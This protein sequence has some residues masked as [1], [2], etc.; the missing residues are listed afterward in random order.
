ME[1]QINGGYQMVSSRLR[2]TIV[3]FALCGLVAGSAFAGVLT[4]APTN[5][6]H[7]IATATTD[8]QTAPQI[9]TIGIAR[10]AGQ[11]FIL[12]FTLSNA[13]F[14]TGPFTLVYGGAALGVANVQRSGGTGATTVEFDVNLTGGGTAIG[15]T[16]TL[17]SVAPN[18]ANIRFAA[19]SAVGTTTTV[20][21]DARD[22]ISALDTVPGPYT[23]TLATLVG[24]ASIFTT[25]GTNPPPNAIID[26]TATVPLTT[27]VVQTS[28][29]ASADDD[30]ALIAKAFFSTSPTTAG[31][32]NATNT[33]DYT[34]LAGD[35]VTISIGGDFSGL[36]Q[37][38][39]NPTNHAAPFTS[40]PANT[41]TNEVFTIAAD[42]RSASI[43][44]DGNRLTTGG[45]I[46]FT[47]TASSAL[48]PRVFS[49]TEA[50]TPVAPSQARTIGTA[51]TWY[52]WVQ[53]G[54]TIV[55]P[56]VSFTPGNGVKFRFTN[57]SGTAIN[58]L[59]AV[60]LDQPTATFT[61]NPS[62]L[63][64]SGQF[65]FPVPAG[66]SQQITFSDLPTANT[67]EIGPI[68]T[69]LLTGVAPV[70]GKVTFTALTASPNVA[71]LELIYSPV[72]VVSLINLPQNPSW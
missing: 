47:K 65:I 57:S 2:T 36:V 51:A 40:A 54:T 6:A 32:R 61:Y 28:V 30:T 4:N 44:V 21:A 27:F 56:Y 37:V 19:A 71:G 10:N 38:V 26:A 53:N 23:R 25:A 1:K 18:G 45:T 49:I 11:N 7:E 63:N 69:A 60:V 33:A 29:P 41:T 8:L 50:I 31:V 46:W 9:Y 52:T 55:A 66:S 42:L 22:V 13:V 12:R 35:K 48:N 5:F 72:G 20:T 70:R 64:A 24:A 39:Y 58:I 67:L 14:G 3:F 68:A 17:Y 62:Y 16:F 59:V 43:T 15:D 34:L